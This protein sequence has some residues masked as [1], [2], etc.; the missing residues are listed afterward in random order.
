MAARVTVVA[1]SKTASIEL[2]AFVN[3]GTVKLPS[4]K[5]TVTALSYTQTSGV[6]SVAGGSFSSAMPVEIKGGTLT[7][8]GLVAAAVVNS[9][10]V[11][12]STT[13]GV[14]T[15]KGSYQQSKSGTFATVLTG[16]TPGT[17]FGQLVVTGAASLAGTVKVTTSHFT[18]RRRQS[19]QVLRFHSHTGSFSR[20]SGTPRFS[21][22]YTGSVHVS[23]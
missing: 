11:N 7:G 22:S 10:T 12:P 14:L 8:H 1:G 15:I 6:T 4:G 3:H 19:F 13:G 2:L 5:L 16:T 18:P 21:V 23:Y 20:Q 17:K 9:G